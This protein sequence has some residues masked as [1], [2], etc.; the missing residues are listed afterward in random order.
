MSQ[1][2]SGT[3]EVHFV[4]MLVEKVGLK[5]LFAP[6]LWHTVYLSATAEVRGP[7]GNVSDFCSGSRNDTC[8]LLYC[9]DH[10]I[11]CLRTSRFLRAN[12]QQVLPPN[13]HGRELQHADL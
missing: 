11:Q 7:S 6:V 4:Q 1:S 10:D 9:G 8:V 5:N 13:A 2:R 12:L 3:I